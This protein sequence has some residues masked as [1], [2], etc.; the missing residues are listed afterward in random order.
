MRPSLK[1]HEKALGSPS[2]TTSILATATPSDISRPKVQ[3]HAATQ[4][5]LYSKSNVPPRGNFI[6][7]HRQIESNF[8]ESRNLLRDSTLFLAQNHLTAK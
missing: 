5:R 2:E 6:H 1:E 3:S 7:H 8:F 4:S